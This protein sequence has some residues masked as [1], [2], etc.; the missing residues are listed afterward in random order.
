MRRLSFPAAERLGRCLVEDVGVPRSRLPEM[1]DAIERIG[2]DRG[3]TVL[4]VAH[5]GDGNIHPTFVFEPTE[6]GDAPPAVWDA[7]DEIF[8]TALELG[9][10]LTGEHGVGVLKRRWLELELG[11]DV[12]DVHRSIKGALDPTGILNPGKGF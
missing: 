12:M 7:A 9:G 3:V 6:D 8:R 1:L 10:T 2:R 5:A 4:T 11:S